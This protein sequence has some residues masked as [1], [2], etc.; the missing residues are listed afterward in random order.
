MLHRSV[1]VASGA[2]WVAGCSSLPSSVNPVAWWHDL[3]GGAIAEQ[4]PP[5]PG[6]TDPYP[7]LATVPPKPQASDLA[8]RRALAQSLVADRTNAQHAAEAAPIPDPSLPSAS[9]ALFGRGSAAPPPPPPPPPPDP[10]AATAS[11]EAATAP[12]PPPQPA[13]APQTAGPPATVRSSAPPAPAPQ[14]AAPARLAGQ[15][16]PLGPLPGA[17]ETAPTPRDTASLPPLPQAPPSPP[18]LAGPGAPQV[19]APAAPRAPAKPVP[20]AAA[21]PPAPVQPETV[22]V[23]FVRGSARL[24]SAEAASLRQ[25]AA[26]RGAARI[27]VTGYGE[28]SSNG[29]EAQFE[30]L[31]LGL[32]RAQAMATVLTQAGVPPAAVRLDAEALGRGGAARLIN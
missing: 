32:N 23:G 14:A 13:S 8:A 16:T 3:Q 29:P 19:P 15:G 17:E 31:G 22:A 5:P 11:L 7:N 20:A 25:L 12:A 26:K 18:R 24:P 10:N 21:A 28:A 4:R 2:V 9:A 30:A 27:A 1:L 6:A